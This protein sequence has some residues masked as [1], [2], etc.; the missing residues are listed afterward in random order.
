MA[1]N[2]CP[3]VAAWCFLRISFHHR[4]LGQRVASLWFYIALPLEI[5][6]METQHIAVFNGVGDGVGVQ[7]FLERSSVV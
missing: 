1:L 5:V 7:P 6:D 4:L 2:F 3:A